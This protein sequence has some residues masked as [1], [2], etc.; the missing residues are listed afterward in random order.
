MEVE[1]EVTDY[2]ATFQLPNRDEI[3]LTYTTIRPINDNWGTTQS[4]P[5]FYLNGVSISR[6]QLPRAITA[7]IIAELIATAAISSRRSDWQIV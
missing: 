6:S 1:I 7:E 5:E 3:S 4:E 2:I